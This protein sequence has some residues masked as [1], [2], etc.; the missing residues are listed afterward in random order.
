MSLFN[1]TIMFPSPVTLGTK[2]E[3]SN[4]ENEKDD[5]GDDAHLHG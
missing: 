3:K 4:A 1:I 2:R 5:E